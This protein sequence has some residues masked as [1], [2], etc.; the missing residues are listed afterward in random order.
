MSNEMM[1]REMQEAVNAGEQALRSLNAA[2]EKL[3]SAR[4]WGIFDL[5]GGGVLSD[6]MK[7]SKMNDA[8]AL[9]ERAKRD[10]Q[11]FQREL[12]DVQ[13]NLNLHM[14]IGS[15]LSFADFFF[16][17][18]VADYLVQSK[19]TEAREQ[20]DDA[21]RYV[22]RIVSDVKRQ[23]D[24][25]MY[26]ITNGLL[27]C[28]AGSIIKTESGSKALAEAVSWFENVLGNDAL[29]K[30]LMVLNCYENLAV[31]QIG[32]GAVIGGLGILGQYLGFYGLYQTFDNKESKIAKA[33]FVG[34]IGFAFVGSLVYFVLCVLMYVYKMNA[35]ST[36]C[37]Q[38][39]GE[40]SLWFIAPLLIIFFI[41]YGIFS[42]AM[43]WQMFKKHT[44]FPKWFCILNPIIGKAVFGIVAFLLPSSAFANA[45]SN[46]CMGL[47]SV[48]I[49]AIMLYYIKGKNKQNK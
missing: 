44:V 1:R 40:F 15:F 6:V 14:E 8:V 49:L 46:A 45:F 31:W 7:H 11:I 22:Q 47:T 24:S 16:D 19:I 27:F 33:Y 25:G 28:C 38:I 3:N 4:N 29:S 18:F 17:G 34:N 21:I 39:I 48:V 10:L 2:K 37:W 9:M 43:F 23:M 32:L 42:V 12:K 35:N 26:Q 20:V 41:L 36:N 30:E 5:F 13:I